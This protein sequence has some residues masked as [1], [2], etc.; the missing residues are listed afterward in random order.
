MQCPI[1]GKSHEGHERSPGAISVVCES[2]GQSP[3]R[4]QPVRTRK[5][6]TVKR[7][8]LTPAQKRE[9]VKDVP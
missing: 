7:N 8:T 1:C 5:K 9:E 4:V 2:C 6:R 3:S